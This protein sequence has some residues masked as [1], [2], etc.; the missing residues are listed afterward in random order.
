GAIATILT[1][2]GLRPRDAALARLPSAIDRVLRRRGVPRPPHR[3]M[4][5]H[6][7]GV[8]HAFSQSEARTLTEAASGFLAAEFGGQ[9][10][11]REAERWLADIS[12]MG[13]SRPETAN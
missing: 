7:A 3:P 5:A 11:A 12:G 10:S 4:L 13:S 1:L 2:I 6:L 8:D 9:P